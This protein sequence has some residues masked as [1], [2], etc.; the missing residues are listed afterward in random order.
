MR[1]KSLIQHSIVLKKALV[2]RKNPRPFNPTEEIAPASSQ[3]PA[4]K[5]HRREGNHDPEKELL[6]CRSLV[7]V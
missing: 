5:G 6:D 3:A 2:A 7:P 4:K 1:K